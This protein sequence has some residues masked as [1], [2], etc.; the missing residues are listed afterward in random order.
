MKI[1][2]QDGFTLIEVIVVAAIIAILAGVLVPMILKEIDETRITRAGADIRSISNAILVFKKDTAQWPVMDGTCNPGLTLLR[3]GGNPPAGLGAN[4]WDNTSV[5]AMDDHLM[6]DDGGCYN[7]WK[8]P[9]LP[10]VS[11]DPWGN[12]YLINAN[13]FGVANNPVWIISAGP[14]GSL[15]M[16]AGASTTAGTDDIA[17]RIQ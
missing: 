8:G 1:K 6:I 9:Y 15:D 13:L 7:N 4:G 16:V 3:G 5:S 2:G 14:N 17:V 11:A 10:S 12:Q